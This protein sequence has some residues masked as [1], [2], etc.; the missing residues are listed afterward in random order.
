[1]PTCLN[2][3]KDSKKAQEYRKKQRKQNYEKS[4]KNAF[5]SNQPWT[6]AEIDMILSNDLNDREISEK[7]GRSVQAI[8]GKRNRIKAKNQKATK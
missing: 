8:Q 2:R 3:Y 1:M 6:S 5:A 7:I 4:R